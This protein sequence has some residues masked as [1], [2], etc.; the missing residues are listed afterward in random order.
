[1]SRY[2]IGVDIGGTFTD[3][4]VVGSDGS[5]FVGKVPSTPHDFSEGFFASIA[6]AAAE[7]DL[8]LEALLAATDRIAH[9]TTV[10]INALVTR[11]GARVALLTTRGH[12][13]ALKIM[14]N[15]GRVTG[16]SVEE[17]LDYASSSLPT[18]FV[19]VPF[20]R[21][22]TERVDAAGD[23][24][25]AL[26]EQQ[27]RTEIEELASVGVEAIAV[28]LLWSFVN[29]A[30]E[31]R[32]AELVAE[33][34]PTLFVS[35][36]HEVAPRIDEYPRT[37][38]TVFN[39]YIGP[40]MNA[41]ISLI[42]DRLRQVGYEGEIA[43]AT[44]TGGLV[45]ESVARSLPILTLQSG[46][47]GG[48]VATE[49]LGSQSGL[50]NVIT[51]DMGGTTL[52]VG[53][54]AGGRP[55]VRNGAVI[56][57][58]RLHLRIVDVD[59]IGAGGGSI[60][61]FEPLSRSLRVGPQSA[62]ADPGPACYGRG[63]TE[64]TVTD[65]DLVLGILSPEGL[66]GGQMR[67]DADAANGAIEKL[68][69]QVG[70]GRREC[71]A[72]MIEI[73]DSR[74]EDLLRRM[75]IQ[76]GLDPRDFVLFGYGGGAAAHASLYGRGLGL[77]RLVI[78]LGNVASVWSALGVALADVARTYEQALQ[79]AV[80]F[81][82]DVIADVYAELE[83]RARRDLAQADGASIVITRSADMRYGLQVFEVE[84]PVPPGD[85]RDEAAMHAIIESFERAY[86]ARYGEGSGYREAG[87][88]LSALRVEARVVGTRPSF[89]RR[90]N[91]G[92]AEPTGTRAVYWYELGRS[93]ET[94]IYTV[95][96]LPAGTEI[97][98]PV[99]VECPDTTVVVRPGQQLAADEWGNFVVELD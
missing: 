45:D 40:Q 37:A 19:T 95:E 9:G 14:D 25:V 61:W 12:A 28:T 98:G 54:V 10:G 44:T 65:A 22:I 13:D 6:A 56:E 94:P 84:A 29:P 34:A 59:S 76:R 70:L 1:M 27:A 17:I 30:H 24:V 52:D 16:A 79:L 87:M 96:T 49:A 2:R 67:L 32:L 42:A 47:V 88:I 36:S 48:V 50:E 72:G 92:R 51:S 8:E 71:A 55:I 41:Y 21:E 75:T 78:P 7:T 90:R 66:L 81:P 91:G 77:K 74:M 85:L 53:V 5:V 31:R 46:P 15:T 99:I 89:H 11:T 4:A 80:P 20:I 39:A 60:G 69:G 82:P 18:Q 58:H 97:E 3:C 63:G 73:V 23:V 64:P 35:L 26:D 57:R 43:F 68:A 38:T 86:A 83:A 93:T 33:V 62:G